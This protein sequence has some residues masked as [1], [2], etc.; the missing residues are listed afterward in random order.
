M[1]AIN[2]Y[3]LSIFL[4]RYFIDWI[5]FVKVVVVYFYCPAIISQLCGCYGYYWFHQVSLDT[6]Q[7]IK[8]KVTTSNR[9]G[10]SL[11]FFLMLCSH[12]LYLSM[13]HPHD[14]SPPWHIPKSRSTKC[15]GRCPAQGWKVFK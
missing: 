2:E 9:F 14:S 13:C 10:W 7:P 6:R 4:F 15:E 5:R 1:G 8:G 3:F 12:Y 11:G